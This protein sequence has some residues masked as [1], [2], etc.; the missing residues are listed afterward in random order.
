[1]FAR[2]KFFLLILFTLIFIR[3]FSYSILTHEAIV[4]AAW[5]GTIRPALLA[6]YPEG[7]N[8]EALRN[9]KAFAYGGAIMPD[10]GYFPFGNKMF[11]NLI[12]YVRG[13]DFINA[14]ISQATNMNE[15]A[16]AYGAMAHYTSDNYGHP[17]GVNPSVPLLYKKMK[18]KFGDYVIYSQN[19]ISHRRV[20]FAFDIIQ[21][22][23][24]QYAPKAYHNFIGFMVAEEQ[25]KRAFLQ[26][27]CIPIDELFS[28]FRTSVG[29]FRW[30]VITGFPILTRAAWRSNKSKV[31][32]ANRA[33]EKKKTV[34]NFHGKDQ[35]V[36]TTHNKKPGFLIS[37]M[38]SILTILP[39]VGTL[40]IL[41]FKVPTPQSEALFAQSFETSLFHLDSIIKLPEVKNLK[42]VN[43]DLDTGLD[44]HPGDDCLADAT[45]LLLLRK[46]RK[47]K[48]DGLDESL[49]NHILYYFSKPENS[50]SASLAPILQ[51][52]KA[53]KLSN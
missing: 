44:S 1:M 37:A 41:K 33:A 32:K 12:H 49:R 14:L 5:E 43:K 23:R 4:D 38:A 7:D 28:N 22:S 19:P 29:I 50:L 42:L 3:S 36:W 48:Y 2:N 53:V 40:K 27:Y 24:G 6:K 9:A 20:E 47:K 31:N 18:K 39:K 21:V 52:I 13:G 46:L 16:F 8:P 51:E 26:T 10:M 45:Y 25:L 30:T 35:T 11:T 15:L 17:I 34:Y